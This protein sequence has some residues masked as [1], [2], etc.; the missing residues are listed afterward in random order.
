[1]TELATQT[2]DAAP[3]ELVSFVVPAH[4]EEAFL[5]RTL[6][7]LREAAEKLQVRYELIVVDDASTDRTAEVA[8]ECDATVV[9]VHYRRISAVRNAGFRHA[10]GD[11]VVFVDADTIVPPDTLRGALDAVA[12]GAVG[13]GARIEFEG[14]TGYGARLLAAVGNW[15]AR[16]R[17]W[18]AGCFI[19]LRRQALPPGDPFDESYY[20][21]E[22]I[23]FSDRMKRF[24]RYVILPHAVLTSDRK[25]ACFGPLRILWALV[26]LAIK[27]RRSWQDPDAVRRWWY[28]RAE[29]RSL[30]D[31]EQTK[32]PNAP[33]DEG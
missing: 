3:I 14:Q 30:P 25:L 22:E 18:S 16:L 9:S 17:R 2:S 7:A 31:S 15:T 28:D 26:R 23:V 21:G 27:G 10:S 33:K 5:G 12:Q 19:F 4:N 20:A 24:G 1:V 29:A 11:V 13:G 32:R 8:G 6:A